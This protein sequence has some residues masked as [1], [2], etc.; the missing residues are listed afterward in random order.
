MKRLI[1]ALMS[2]VLYSFVAPTATAAPMDNGV[3]PENLGTG[4]W[5]Y[6]LSQ[7]VNRLGGNVDTV[8]D[9]PSLMSYYKKAGIDFIIVKS[10]TGAE[11]F[12][13]DEPQFTK[14]LVEAAH[15]EGLKIFGYNRSSGVDVPAEIALAIQDLDL[16]ADGYVIDAESEWEVGRLKNAPE[17]A[18][19][20]CKGIKARYPNKFLG[21]APFPIITLHSSFP[22]KEFGLYCDA[23]MPQAYWKSIKVPPTQM[24]EWMNEEWHAWHK[25]LAPE[26]KKAIKPI[27]PIAQAW[28]PDAERTLQPHE[29]IEFITALNHHPNPAS[30]TGYKGVSYWRTDLQTA[31]MWRSITKA[32]IGEIN[33]TPLELAK[34]QTL[35]SKNG[36]ARK[37]AP[38]SDESEGNNALPVTKSAATPP[39][40]PP[41]VAR[42]STTATV[43]KTAPVIVQ[44]PN[45]FSIDN[46]HA[47]V[48]MAGNWY[49]GKSGMGF[50]GTNYFCA[51]TTALG[52]S[53]AT[54]VYR[55]VIRNSGRYDVFVWYIPHQNR[56]TKVPYFVSYEG[57][58]EIV[59]VNQTVHVGGWYPICKGKLFSSGTEGF[60][61]VSNDTGEKE[62]V[63]TMDAVRFVRQD[64]PAAAATIG[65]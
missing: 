17:K 13:K 4:Q 25:S 33:T 51:N 36:H 37:A 15:A 42:A 47:D 2:A 21:H 45:D 32:Q 5:I 38:A 56:S 62:K 10:A 46:D 61:S 49:A 3:D 6:F 28:S 55:P 24:V 31:G 39:A 54:A 34:K 65:N 50:K 1:V 29:I 58:S 60:I 35:G 8:N 22:Y 52:K 44:N 63:I 59:T 16:G 18:I 64:D 27:A 53:T 14:E 20:L 48:T 11:P 41:R 40:T 30:P 7:A 9:V 26:D 19:Q 23:V 12:L 57:G 43:Q